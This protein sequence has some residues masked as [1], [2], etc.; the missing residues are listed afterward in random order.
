MSDETRQPEERPVDEAEV[1]AHRFGGPVERKGRTDEDEGPEVEAHRFGG[2]VER[3]GR[4]DED[5]GPEVEGHRWGK[6]S[7]ADEPQ[8]RA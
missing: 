7:P 5:D 1:E 8:R 4:T 3:K 6:F 2:P